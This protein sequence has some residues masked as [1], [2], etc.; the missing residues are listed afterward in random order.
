MGESE[1]I[2]V[3]VRKYPVLQ[4]NVPFEE[5]QNGINLY[6]SLNFIVS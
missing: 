2:T 4:L 1:P 5:A 3:K 6:L